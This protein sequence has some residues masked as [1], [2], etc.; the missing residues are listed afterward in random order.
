MSLIIDLVKLLGK[1]AKDFLPASSHKLQKGGILK[2]KQKSRERVI[3]DQKVLINRTKKRRLGKEERRQKNT[4]L[5]TKQSEQ[6]A[7][8]IGIKPSVKSRRGKKD[9]TAVEERQ[10]DNAMARREKTTI[11]N[12]E[13]KVDILDARGNKIGATKGRSPMSKHANDEVNKIMDFFDRVSR[14]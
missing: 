8:S 13:G 12:D 5:R 4:E 6:F 11:A 3:Q 7:N 9:I 2:K 1:R 14:P 10:L